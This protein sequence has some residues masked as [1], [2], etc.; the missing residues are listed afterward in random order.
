M[1]PAVVPI[2][3]QNNKCKYVLSISIISYN[4]YLLFQEHQ[5]QQIISF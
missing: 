2:E 1:L 3:L 4:Q 5:F